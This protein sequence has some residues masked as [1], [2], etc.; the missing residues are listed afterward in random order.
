MIPQD[1]QLLFLESVHT[2]PLRSDLGPSSP[3]SALCPMDVTLWPGRQNQARVEGTSHVNLALSF[4]SC[5]K[6][7][8][9]S[10]SALSCHTWSLLVGMPTV[11][12]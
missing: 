9:T 11:P 12:P 2:F 1:L 6:E 5:C 7:V 4:H 10:F 3:L 8:D